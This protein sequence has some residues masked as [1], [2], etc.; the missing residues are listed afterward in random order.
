MKW[1]QSWGDQ[2]K[3]I[4]SGLATRGSR[5]KTRNARP[6]FRE[7]GNWKQGFC[8]APRF[9]ALVMRLIARQGSGEVLAWIWPARGL[10]PIGMDA[11]KDRVRD[12]DRYRETEWK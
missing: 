1:R 7:S 4:G 5:R 11:D 12:R 2:S 9:H 6:R 10:Q 3:A 8:V